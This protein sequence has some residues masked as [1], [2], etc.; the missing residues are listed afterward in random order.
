M[1]S[2][3]FRN[4]LF[5]RAGEIDTD[6][7]ELREHI[8][9]DE[10]YKED[11]AAEYLYSCD[12]K[13]KLNSLLFSQM[14][15]GYNTL[16]NQ[17]DWVPLFVVPYVDIPPHVDDNVKKKSPYAKKYA[18]IRDTVTHSLLFPSGKYGNRVW[19]RFEMKAG[20]R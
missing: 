14:E 2:C 7:R 10:I 1:Q 6:G 15:A 8:L 5:I 16:K 13:R 19:G 18:M 20:K 12:R 3:K 11:R 17:R 4:I 9:V